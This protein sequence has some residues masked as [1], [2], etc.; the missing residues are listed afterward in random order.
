MI[1][2]MV[3]MSIIVF[4]TGISLKVAKFSDTHKNLTMAADQMRTH[5]RLS[6]SYAL[7]VPRVGTDSEITSSPY[8]CGFGVIVTSSNEYALFY[9][10]RNNYADCDQVDAQHYDNAAPGVST[11]LERFKLP[12]NVNFRATDVNTGGGVGRN[13]FFKVPYAEAYNYQGAALV[14]DT[15]NTYNTE[16][17]QVQ[18]TSDTS[19]FKTISIFSFGKIE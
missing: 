2:I 12:D 13:V 19:V 7:A 15:A 17:F 4:L 10:R 8:L 16:T 9:N 14:D 5:I 11:I 1:E 18:Q 6:Q 3:A